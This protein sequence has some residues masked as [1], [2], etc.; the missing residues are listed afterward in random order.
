[1]EESRKKNPE[2]PSKNSWDSDK[3]AYPWDV[4]VSVSREFP[5]G[6]TGGKG[7]AGD[8]RAVREVRTLGSW[9]KGGTEGAQL[10][11]GGRQGHQ[12]PWRGFGLFRTFVANASYRS[13][14]AG[15][16]AANEDGSL[17]EGPSEDSLPEQVISFCHQPPSF[18]GLR[19]SSKVHSSTL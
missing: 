17:T 15:S 3:N 9:H 16:G 12:P 1:M 8:W 14:P 11:G 6:I 13:H 10:L 2:F 19:A 7:R 5:I 18:I 4:L